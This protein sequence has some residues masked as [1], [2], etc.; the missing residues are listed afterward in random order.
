MK[1]WLLVVSA[2]AG[3]SL[4][5]PGSGFAQ[6]VLPNQ[7]GLYEFSDGTGTTGT[8][9]IGMP[10][11]IFLVLTKPTDTQN[12]DT[13]YTTINAFECML[14]FVPRGDMFLLSDI[15]PPDATNSGDNTDVKTGFLEYVVEIGND[16]PVTEESVALITFAFMHTAPG[17]I[18]I[19]L[20]PTSDPII[21]GEMAFQSVSGEPQVMYPFQTP[22]YVWDP[23]TPAE[24]QTFGRVKALYR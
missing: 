11:T 3:L 13:P 14:E 22:A 15:L 4:L 23:G 18:G 9:D 20:I 10:V 16:F 5:A 21:P 7:V 8:F 12:E 6:H 2:I 1:K 19:N 24:N 17:Y